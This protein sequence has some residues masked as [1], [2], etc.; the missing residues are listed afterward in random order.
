MNFSSPDIPSKKIIFIRLYCLNADLKLFPVCY[1]LQFY[2]NTDFS[3]ARATRRINEIYLVIM[4]WQVSVDHH[5]C[6]CGR[7]QIGIAFCIRDDLLV[8]DKASPLAD[9]YVVRFYSVR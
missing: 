8:T 1:V 5:Q 7:M 2:S 4:A 9:L 6:V 3:S